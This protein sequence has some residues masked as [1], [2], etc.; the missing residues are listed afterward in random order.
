MWVTAG[1]QD[2]GIAG[3]AN[4]VNQALAAGALDEMFLHVVP[5]TLGAGERLFEGVGDVELEPAEVV[6]SPA[7][8]HIRYR[9]KR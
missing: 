5:I 3:G 8:T 9:R 6:A 1:E 4:I 2:V 7:V